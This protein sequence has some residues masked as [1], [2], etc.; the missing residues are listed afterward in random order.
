LFQITGTS[1]SFDDKK[2][3]EEEGGIY[4]GILHSYLQEGIGKK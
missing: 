3:K 4:H 1:V 2:G